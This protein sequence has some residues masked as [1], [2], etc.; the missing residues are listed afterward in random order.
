[1]PSKAAKQLLVWSGVLVLVG[2]LSLVSRFVGLSPWVWAGCLVGAGLGALGLYGA[3]RSDGWMLLAA[4]ILWAIAGLI[5]LVPPDLLRGEAVAVYVLLAIAL[6]FVVTYVR[7]RGQW[8]AL[9]VA[10]PLLVVVG[11]LGLVASRLVGDDLISA[12]VLLA[13]AAP[14]LVTYARDRARWWALIPGGILA[15]M[16]LSFGSW[17][18]WHSVRSFLMAAISG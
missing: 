2:V 8:W 17:L 12:C 10:Y 11:V 7:D 9:L 1:M 16:G 4:Y 6:P 5:A 13:A 14:F 3:D 15:V 18:P